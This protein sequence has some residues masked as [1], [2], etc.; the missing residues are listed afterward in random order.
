MSDMNTNAKIFIETCRTFVEDWRKGTGG[1]RDWAGMIGVLRTTKQ[2]SGESLL[3]VTVSQSVSR[4]DS[5][6]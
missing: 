2:K 6:G 5:S 1:S 4:Y 3:L